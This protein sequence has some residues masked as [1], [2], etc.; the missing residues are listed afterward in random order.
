[1]TIQGN[2]F[3]EKT[4]PSIGEEE[5]KTIRREEKQRI[6]LTGGVLTLELPKIPG[7]HTHWFNDVPGRINRALNGGWEWVTQEEANLSNL[8]SYGEAAELS[9]NSDLGSRVSLVV[10]TAKQGGPLRAYALKIRDGWWA[11]DQAKNEEANRAIDGTIRR[12]MMGA[13]GDTDG[14]ARHRRLFTAQYD[15]EKTSPHR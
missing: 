14:D 1:M 13:E 12:G 7:Y 6:P 4:N 5:A 9:G 3:D 8:R 15:P 11:E 10:G 2:R